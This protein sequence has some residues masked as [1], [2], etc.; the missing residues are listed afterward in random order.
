VVART[1]A[2]ASAGRL[3]ELPGGSPALAAGPDGPDDD[4]AEAGQIE[5]FG[6]FDPLADDTA[7]W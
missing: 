4:A 5:P 1:T 2:A 7:L 6:V 3:P